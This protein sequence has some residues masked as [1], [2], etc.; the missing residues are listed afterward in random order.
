MVGD[1]V[2]PVAGFIKSVRM[3]ADSQGSQAVI[4]PRVGCGNGSHGRLT[5]G[6]WRSPA[7]LRARSRRLP[8]VF[9]GGVAGTAAT[10]VA[11][12]V[13]R[14]GLDILV[15]VVVG[16][17]IVL[18]ERTVGDWLGEL[19]GS[20]LATIVLGTCLA[21]VAWVVFEEGGIAD[22]LFSAAEQRGYH[23]S[24]YEST[25]PPPTAS[26]PMVAVASTTGASPGPSPSGN[27][28]PRSGGSLPSA[29]GGVPAGQG[30]AGI[31][32]CHRRFER[33]RMVPWPPS[34]THRSF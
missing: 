25:K 14:T 7:T 29:A 3:T 27:S 11:V 2:D 12:E 4:T 19:L 24:Y 34:R 26:G 22:Q 10:A 18:I 23:T 21:A 6:L 28:R 1:R 9:W 17:I 33:D 16:L 5:P 30:A 15:L 8:R 31:G 32:W 20:G 13:T